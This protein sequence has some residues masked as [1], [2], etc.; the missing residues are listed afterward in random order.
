M[1]YRIRYSN[2]SRR[3]LDEIWDYIATELQNTPA[4]V[5]IVNAIMDSVDQLIDFAEMGAPLSSIA[6]VESDY[7]FLVHGNYLTF[8]RV[9]GDEVYVDRVLYGRRDY[10][11]ILFGDVLEEEVE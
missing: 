11:R 4:A 3:D 9:Q 6:N 1:K 10:L 2:Q 5:R 8:Y 7:R